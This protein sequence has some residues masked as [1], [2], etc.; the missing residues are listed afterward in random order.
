MRAESAVSYHLGRSTNG[1]SMGLLKG[2][3]E[4]GSGGRRGHSNMSHW[5]TTE[6]IKVATRKR[7]RIVS[8]E[9]IAR[10]LKEADSTEHGVD[11]K[12][13]SRSRKK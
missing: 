6:E 2:K 13:S 4:G 9:L 10:E 11:G 7:R 12:P 8:K 3:T 1:A 5:V